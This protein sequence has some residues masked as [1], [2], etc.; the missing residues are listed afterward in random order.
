MQDQIG[1]RQLAALVEAGI[2]L[3]SELELDVLLQRIANLSR[4][5]IGARYGAVGV[6][7]SEGRLVRFVHS[8]ISEERVK[9][10]GE[11]PKGV[12]LLGVLIE[13]G[14]PLRL[15]E[16][17]DHPKSSG[18][19]EHHPEMHSFLGVP[20]IGRRRILGRLYLTEKESER[21]FSKDDERIAM[22]FAA[23]A[24][25][26]I[27]N[28]N[29]YEEVRRRSTELARRVNELSSVERVAS[30][31]ITEGAAEETLDSIAHEARHLT[32]ADSTTISLLNEVTGELV[33]RFAS[34]AVP[35][36]EGVVGIR[37]APAS[38]K[39]H[40]ALSRL[41]PQVAADLAADPEVHRETIGKL[42]HP[43]AGAFVPLIVRGKGVGVLSAYH[44]DVGRTFHE[45]DLSILQILA[46]QAAIALENERLTEALK[47]LAVLEERERISKEL[48]DGVIQS[49]YSVGLHLQG[50][51]SLMQRDPDTAAARIEASINELDNVVRDVRSYIFELLP[52]QAKE[53]GV[54][55]TIRG[56]GRDL[57]VNTLANV[58]VYADESVFLGLDEQQQSDVIQIV[59]EVV[60]NTARHAQAGHVVISAASSGKELVVTVEDDG[61]GYDPDSVAR[62]HGLDNMA[63]RAERLGGTVDI[64]RGESAG[65]KHMLRIP[66]PQEGG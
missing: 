11:L 47:D 28:A 1:R 37:L 6:V 65:M 33:I 19:P 8:G 31:L 25:V 56:L 3:A 36:N 61:V 59:R 32:D 50:S 15:H 53:R 5:V 44:R 17:K 46:N 10:I 2:S 49:I 42:R 12:G 40:G 60:S 34:E 39:A 27:E 7:D 18:W 16:I 22:M 57:E 35:T 29:L 43:R 66:L 52:K 30:L 21:D 4:D 20:I 58:E 14:R 9:E 45:D 63:R 24:G 13:E 23:Q 38:S 51:M 26:A 64:E 41:A 54:A 62:G 55:E 48:H